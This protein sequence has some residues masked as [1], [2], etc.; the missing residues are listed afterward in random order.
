MSY[1]TLLPL[2]IQ[3]EIYKLVFTNVLEELCNSTKILRRILDEKIGAKDFA[4]DRNYSWF[5][6]KYKGIGHWTIH[7]KNKWS[8][9]S[10]T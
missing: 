6:C 1:F 2:E 5:L 4:N 7:L 8:V 3:K 9:F 10:E